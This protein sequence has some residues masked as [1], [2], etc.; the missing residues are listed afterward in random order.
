M[1]FPRKPHPF[2]NEYH[3]ACCGLTGILFVMEMVEGKDRP[4]E[5]GKAEFEHL[6]K[7]VGLLLR[8]LKSIFHTGRYI[9]LDS[10][11]CV[12]KALIELKKRGV[13]AAALIKKRR[14]WPTRVPGD[15]MERYFLD[16]AVG[17]VDAIEGVSDGVPYTLWAMKEPDYVMRMMATGGPLTADDT[18][19][20]T[21]RR[22][23]G[24]TVNFQYT[25]PYDWHFRYRHA[26][27]DHN[28]LRHALPSLEDTWR[29]TRWEIRVFTFLLAVTE[30]NVYL[31]L[32]WFV[33]IGA[34]K[35][36]LPKYHEFRRRLAWL[37][38]DNPHITTQYTEPQLDYFAH[39]AD[40]K[41]CVAPKFASFYKNRKWVCEAKT[42]YPQYTCQVPGCSKTIRTYCACNPGIWL[43]TNHIL[44]HVVE[45]VIKKTNNS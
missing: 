31:V 36:L 26:V 18:C 38:I 32:R 33:C 43:C 29:T 42:T 1:F 9:I 40:H 28:N 39:V 35:K 8:M 23:G 6:G 17:E 37:F 21:T 14:Y 4:K 22:V 15:A 12:L 2:G 13:F 11:F 41:V 45:E 25:R 20:E 27:D 30:V 10:G 44:Q 24:E 19:R 5:L 3:T 7:T 34:S 16:K